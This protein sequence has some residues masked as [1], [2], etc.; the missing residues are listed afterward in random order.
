MDEKEL[1]GIIDE[2]EESQTN[3]NNNA[4]DYNEDESDVYNGMFEIETNNKD[5]NID[6]DEKNPENFEVNTDSE[7]VCQNESIRMN[8]PHDESL[9]EKSNGCSNHESI[10]KKSEA[11]TLSP[12]KETELTLT[13]ENLRETTEQL[14]TDNSDQTN[15]ELDYD[16][17]IDDE[18]E[19][20]ED[21]EDDD[22]LKKPRGRSNHWSERA[23]KQEAQIQNENDLINKN[24][25]YQ[26]N[27]RNNSNNRNN[28]NNNNNYNNNNNNNN[29]RFQP[30][31]RNYARNQ[32]IQQQQQQQSTNN[33][34]I[35][36]PPNKPMAN[37]MAGHHQ[38]AQ[39]HYQMNSENGPILPLLFNPQLGLSSSSIASSSGS[40]SSS[41][42]SP[43][44]SQQ[45]P[46][47][48]P[49]SR[50]QHN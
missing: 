4:G 24:N 3:V 7:N 15:L 36:Q 49:S 8:V 28:N 34:F 20:E 23:K 38:P 44:I 5:D 32:T 27:H 37:H 45:L 41:S 47:P 14:H 11:E 42:S 40:S 12:K 9:A 25:N 26:N 48:M 39:Q 35:N 31:P 1:L 2:D 13:E 30:K 21:E 6:A 18:E 17:K 16:E 22:G 50:G 19:E 33:K 46:M 10:L 29:N 43:L